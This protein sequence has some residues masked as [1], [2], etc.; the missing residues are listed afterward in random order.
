MFSGCGLFKKEQTQKGPEKPDKNTMI[1]EITSMK[2][3]NSSFIMGTIFPQCFNRLPYSNLYYRALS[4]SQVALV[5]YKVNEKQLNRYL[6]SHVKMEKGIK[7][8]SLYDA[9]P[10]KKVRDFIKQTMKMNPDQYQKNPPLIVN[11]YIHG[12][13]NNCYNNQTYLDEI[14]E[15]TN[16]SM[17]LKQKQV[18]NKE[19]LV[20][21]YSRYFS[22]EHQAAVLLKTVNAYDSIKTQLKH[23]NFYYKAPDYKK[24]AKAKIKASPHLNEYPEQLRKKV[25]KQWVEK[26]VPEVKKQS[27]FMPIPVQYLTGSDGILK[28]LRKKG[29]TVRPYKANQRKLEKKQIEKQQSN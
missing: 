13:I 28:K 1:W 3:G 15:S 9:K 11:R 20:K 14:L 17:K 16:K 23:M 27:T 21:K 29:F 4:K 2:S 8:D 7:L 5:P 26:L 6:L 19:D 25:I 12:N 24:A 22:Y 18:F 10:R